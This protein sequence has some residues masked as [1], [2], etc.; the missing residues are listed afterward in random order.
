MPKKIHIWV[1]QA[2][3]LADVVARRCALELHNWGRLEKKRDLELEELE[4]TQNERDK[5]VSASV[6]Y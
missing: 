3:G 5:T 2:A 4:K 1:L 6:F